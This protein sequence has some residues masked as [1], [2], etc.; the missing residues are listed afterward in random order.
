MWLQQFNGSFQQQQREEPNK[1]K[2]KR[3]E[4]KTIFNCLW[5][6]IARANQL[7]TID[8]ALPNPNQTYINQYELYVRMG[9]SKRIKIQRK[10]QFSNLKNCLCEFSLCHDGTMNTSAHRMCQ[11]P[12]PHRGL[13]EERKLRIMNDEIDWDTYDSSSFF[14]AFIVALLRYAFFH[15]FFSHFW[16]EKLGF[17]QIPS[18]VDSCS[19][20]P[21]DRSSYGVERVHK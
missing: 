3:T 15:V 7:M 13:A 1:K 10:I 6:K 4:N 14:I 8:T 18:R 16:R 21:G 12:V 20:Y 2:R 19:Q 17:I 5:Q 9:N 11:Q